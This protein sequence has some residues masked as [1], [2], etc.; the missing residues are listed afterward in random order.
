MH[1]DKTPLRLAFLTCIKCGHAW[2]A[3][4]IVAP[5]LCPNCKTY[6][7]NKNRPKIVKGVVTYE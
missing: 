3:R 4:R 2:T 5:K 6:Y 1:D 7:W